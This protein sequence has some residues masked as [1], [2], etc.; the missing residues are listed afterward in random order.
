MAAYR[1]ATTPAVRAKATGTSGACQ[2]LPGKAG[3]A[4]SRVRDA[5]NVVGGAIVAAAMP[6]PLAEIQVGGQDPRDVNTP[7]FSVQLRAAASKK[8]PYAPTP[9]DL[10]RISSVS[11]C[12]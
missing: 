6:R 4:G 9:N 8:W 10:I 12:R 5:A 7:R 1:S 11:H 3:A 2:I